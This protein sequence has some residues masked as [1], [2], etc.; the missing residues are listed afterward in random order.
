MHIALVA[1]KRDTH[2]EP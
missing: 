1:M 2:T